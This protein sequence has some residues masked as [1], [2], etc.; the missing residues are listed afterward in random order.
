LINAKLEPYLGFL[1]SEQFGKPSLVCDFQEL[2]RYMI[3][4]FVVQYCQRLTKRDFILRTEKSSNKKGK[5][6]Y[7]ADVK[8]DRFTSEMNNYFLTIVEVPRIKI[9]K[10]QKIESLINE[11]T[12]LFGKYLRGE[13]KEWVPRIA[14]LT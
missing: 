12:L 1:H 13:R 8:T 3:D 5:R 14:N 4:Y 2:Y 10:R 7:L 9:G 11:E 6:E